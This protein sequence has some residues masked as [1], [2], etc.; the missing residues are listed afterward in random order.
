MGAWVCAEWDLGFVMALGVTSRLC[1][2]MLPTRHL[3]VEGGHCR[4]LPLKVPVG[5]SLALEQLSYPSPHQSTTLE[6]AVLSS[7]KK[8]SNFSQSHPNSF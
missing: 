7:R 5:C 4:N 1:V 6:T 8:S 3:K 2:S